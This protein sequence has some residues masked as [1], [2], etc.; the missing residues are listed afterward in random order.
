MLGAWLPGSMLG[1]VVA[2][3]PKVGLS[4]AKKLAGQRTSSYLHQQE[5]VQVDS[6]TVISSSKHAF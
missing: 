2:P 1:N 5:H 4:L 6:V 3:S